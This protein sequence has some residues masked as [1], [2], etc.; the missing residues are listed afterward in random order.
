MRR[1][2]IAVLASALLASPA[3]AAEVHVRYSTLEKLLRNLDRPGEPRYVS[4]KKGTGNWAYVR[5]P[6]V[7]A[8]RDRLRLTARFSAAVFGR[9]F[10]EMDIAIFAQPRI[11]NGSLALKDAKIL[12]G[13]SPRPFLSFVLRPL[14]A[15]ARID[16]QQKL[17]ELIDSRTSSDGIRF[18]VEQFQVKTIR[19]EENHARLGVDFTLVME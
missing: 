15:K 7:T 3:G 12:V 9:V 2:L 5:A 6:R 18:R 1:L 17:R 19:L 8:D 13:S 11:D 4:G 14:L 16:L 10:K